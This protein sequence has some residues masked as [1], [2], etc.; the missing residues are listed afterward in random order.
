MNLSGSN[1][2]AFLDT[3]QF[4][5]QCQDLLGPVSDVGY[6][7]ASMNSRNLCRLLLH[8]NPNEST[9]A[10]RIILEA[11]ITFIKSSGRFN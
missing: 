6:D 11:T 5:T 10:N 4:T 9:V 1:T 7:V 3:T 8:D 2:V